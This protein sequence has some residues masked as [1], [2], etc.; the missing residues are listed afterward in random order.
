VTATQVPPI[1]I[2]T[3]SAPQSRRDALAEQGAQILVAGEQR[4]DLKSALDQL[5]QRGLRRID[6]EG[7]PHLLGGL[8]A[9]NLVDQLCLTV[10]PL[11]AGAGAAR[12]ALGESSPDTRKMTLASVL[13]E[14]GFLMLRYRGDRAENDVT[15]RLKT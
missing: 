13:H 12:I 15:R 10:A 7:G 3:S 11:L 8:I 1:I 2:T 6:C 4:V 14:K 9:E 5:S